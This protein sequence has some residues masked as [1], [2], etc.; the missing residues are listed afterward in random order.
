MF[1]P[2]K[3]S[4]KVPVNTSAIEQ[5]LSAKTLYGKPLTAFIQ[6]QH[7]HDDVLDISIAIGKTDDQRELE[8]LYH[9]LQKALFEL[10]VAELNFN[11][12][13]SDNAKS[14]DSAQSY[15]QAHKT[16]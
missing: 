10:G 12:Q 15:T 11:V 3:K 14:Q 9:A 2:F 4:K 16:P 6:N 8:A 13:L 5:L 1:N 7:Q